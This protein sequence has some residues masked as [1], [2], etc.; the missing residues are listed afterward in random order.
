MEQFQSSLSRVVN[1]PEYVVIIACSILD[2]ILSCLGT[3]IGSNEE[4]RSLCTSSGTS[5]KFVFNV[6]LLKSF[7]LFPLFL[8]DGSCFGLKLKLSFIQPVFE[9]DLRLQTGRVPDQ[10]PITSTKLFTLPR[11]LIITLK[12]LTV[13]NQSSLIRMFL[14]SICPRSDSRPIGPVAGI[15]RASSRISPLQVQRAILF[16][17]TT[18]ILFHSCG[19]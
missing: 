4:L 15:L 19:L 16:F 5:P 13:D 14:Y 2:Y 10:L 6:F 12:L 1:P 9:P 7:R 3:A 11:K 18:S 8:P 17:T